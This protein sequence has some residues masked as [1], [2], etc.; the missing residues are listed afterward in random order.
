MWLAILLHLPGPPQGNTCPEGEGSK[1]ISLSQL[2]SLLLPFTDAP[3]EGS[4]FWLLVSQ[5]L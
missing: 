5:T 1:P 2:G 3:T 4:R